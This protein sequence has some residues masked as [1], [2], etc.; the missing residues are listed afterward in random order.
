MNNSLFPIKLA[1][2]LV[3]V[4]ADEKLMHRHS[5]DNIQPALPND[6]HRIMLCSPPLQYAIR[7]KIGEDQFRV[8]LAIPKESTS[9]LDRA[10]NTII[11]V[12][13]IKGN[14]LTDANVLQH[15]EREL[16]LAIELELVYALLETKGIKV[17][18]V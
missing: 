16:S 5:L 7:N 9:V 1:G 6:Y 14:L 12:Y 10:R 18:H 13:G 4:L 8:R 11:E 3:H 2:L 17:D 15:I